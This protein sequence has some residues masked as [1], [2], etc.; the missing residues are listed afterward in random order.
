MI[1]SAEFFVNSLLRPAPFQF[2]A[3]TQ[4]HKTRVT[5]ES[6]VNLGNAPEHLLRHPPVVGMALRSGPELAQVVHLAEVGP[7]VPADA[8]SERHDVLGQR[9]AG[10][11]LEPRMDGGRCLDGGPGAFGPAEAFPA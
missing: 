4:V 5:G 1:E 2:V 3:R 10:V 8:E 6:R 11:T 7:E 9:R